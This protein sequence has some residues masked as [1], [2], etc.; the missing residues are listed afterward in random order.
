M[1]TKLYSCSYLQPKKKKKL[2]WKKKSKTDMMWKGNVKLTGSITGL[3]EEGNHF[4][5]LAAMEMYAIIK[6]SISKSILF[7]NIISSNWKKIWVL[8]YAVHTVPH[9]GLK[10][11]K[12]TK[13]ILIYFCLWD[14]CAV[15]QLHGIF[16]GQDQLTGKD[17]QVVPVSDNF[18]RS[19]TSA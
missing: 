1:W 12:S 13:V 10:I 17:T 11:N 16:Q 6:K 7:T 4:L 9:T 19:N 18:L 5:W 3:Q 2:N 15:S 14:L 8:W